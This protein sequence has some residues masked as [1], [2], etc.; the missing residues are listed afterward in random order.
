[1]RGQ[2]GNRLGTGSRC[3]NTVGRWME[4]IRRSMLRAAQG[5]GE[6]PKGSRERQMAAVMRQGVF[7]QPVRWL[8]S[9]L[10]CCGLETEMFRRTAARYGWRHPLSRET[11]A[12]NRRGRLT[13]RETA[14]R[15][16]RMW[17]RP[18]DGTLQIWIRRRSG[19]TAFLLC[20]EV[21][22][23]PMACCQASQRRPRPSR[24]RRGR[25]PPPSSATHGAM[26]EG[27]P[28]FDC[29]GGLVGLYRYFPEWMGGALF[30]SFEGAFFL[31][32]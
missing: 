7:R 11:A 31:C 25:F 32:G 10:K 12:R 22:R 30:S 6:M 2:L 1:M 19:Q 13:P 14:A 18:R 17:K 29:L 24:I 5:C 9:G 26:M 28:S 3:Q 4:N 8:P 21:M 15:L 27:F 16:R 20:G 23:L